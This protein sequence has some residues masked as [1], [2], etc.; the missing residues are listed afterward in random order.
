MALKDWKKVGIDKY[1]DSKIRYRKKEYRG[2]GHWVTKFVTKTEMTK[3]LK[4][5]FPNITTKELKL[6]LKNRQVK[7]DKNGKV[8]S[9]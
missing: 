2:H 7:L 5:S 3:Y 1:K 4:K 9:K 8:M 6:G